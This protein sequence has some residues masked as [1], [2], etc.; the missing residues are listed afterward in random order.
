[1]P[2]A[3]LGLPVLAAIDPRAAR[4]AWAM[5]IV[6]AAGVISWFAAGAGYFQGLAVHVPEA[7][8]VHLLNAAVS[9]AALV[10]IAVAFL[11]GR[12]LA[13]AVW[14][15]PMMGS[16]IAS[17]YATYGLP[18]ALA[19]RRILGGMLVLLPFVAILIDAKFM[20]VWTYALLVPAIAVAA[21][22]FRLRDG[23]A[24]A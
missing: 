21:V 16:Y 10:A 19:R 6:L 4:Y 20:R 5:A 7:G 22:A 3:I 14:L 11:G 18:Y 9:V 17:W 13:S 1:L 24:P 15:M 2:F 12:R 8:F 23:R